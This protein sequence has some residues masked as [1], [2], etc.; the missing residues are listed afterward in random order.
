[1]S[2]YVA[3][4]KHVGDSFQQSGAHSQMFVTKGSN[5]PIT[6]SRSELLAAAA[7]LQSFADELEARG[8]AGDEVIVAEVVEQEQGRLAKV[9]A[10]IAGGAR[11]GLLALVE[12]GVAGLI[13]GILSQ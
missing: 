11:E 9:R 7:E 13:V 10:A 5:S 3:G 2:D 8:I 6:V 12:S 4:N 1:M